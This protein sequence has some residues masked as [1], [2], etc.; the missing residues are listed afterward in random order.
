LRH[1]LD[2]RLRC[3][4]ILARPLYPCHGR[5]SRAFNRRLSLAPRR[6]AGSRIP[7][8]ACS[9][10]GQSR[11]LIIPW[12]LVRIQA[13]P[14][15]ESSGGAFPRTPLALIGAGWSRSSL[16]SCGEEMPSAAL[17][18]GERH[19][20]A[21]PAARPTQASDM[22]GR[23]AQERAA[24]PRYPRVIRLRGHRSNQTIA[25][26]PRRNLPALEKL[27]RLYGVDE[28]LPRVQTQTAPAGA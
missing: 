5:G 13:G 4:R 16:R 27:A 15:Q 26:G 24:R 8:R 2:Q 3:L 23:N 22:P 11:G 6:G 9:S 10:G 14:L 12:S 19:A 18:A 7:P 25:C 1:R 20:G 28:L 17:R 21:P